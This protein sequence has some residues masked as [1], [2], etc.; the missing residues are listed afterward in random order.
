MEKTWW[1]TVTVSC[2]Y[3]E[4][5]T[6]NVSGLH[7]KNKVKKNIILLSDFKW[8]LADNI[9]SPKE[10]FGDLGLD[11]REAL[12]GWATKWYIPSLF[13]AMLLFVLFTTTTK[14]MTIHKATAVLLFKLLLKL[15]SVVM[16]T[17]IWQWLGRWYSAIATYSKDENHFIPTWCFLCLLFVFAFV[18][19]DYIL[20]YIPNR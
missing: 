2:S 17:K 10:Y 12:K 15:M 1:F 4:H 14:K 11:R 13:S 16:F 6:L 3:K 18:N 20:L 19:R 5:V 9:C 8:V 7:L